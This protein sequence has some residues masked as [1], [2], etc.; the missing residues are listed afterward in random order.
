MTPSEA[1]IVAIIEQAISDALHAE[2]G[3][4]ASGSVTIHDQAEARSFLTA[5]TGGWARSRR[6]LCEAVGL[7]PD[8]LRGRMLHLIE[9]TE[10]WVENAQ[11]MPQPASQP[12]R[13]CILDALAEGADTAPEIAAR[14]DA[15]RAA[16]ASQLNAMAREGLV[17]PE[18]PKDG[19]SGRWSATSKRAA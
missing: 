10:S 8:I 5:E 6:D 19:I 15:H 3:K 14:I 4:W 12:L 2:P 16:I 11:P 7:D 17:R 9:Q 18:P 13:F 1:L